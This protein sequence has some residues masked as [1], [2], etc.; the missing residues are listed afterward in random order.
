MFQQG[1]RDAALAE[2][3]QLT[4]KYPDDRAARTRLVAAYGAMNRLADAERELDTALKRNP[5]DQDALWQRGQLDLATG[6]IHQ[7]ENDL[8]KLVGFRSDSADV[9]F[10]MATVHRLKREPQLE[11]QELTEA[12]RL[13]SSF[14]AA[15]LTLARSF[16]A[17]GQ[18]E[19]ALHVLDEAPKPQKDLVSLLLERNWALLLSG[20]V[21]GAQRMVEAILKAKRL[22]DAVLQD[23]VIKMVNRN[24]AGAAQQAEEVLHAS[25]SDV[26]A[27]YLLTDA[28]LAEKQLP[29]AVERVRQLVAQNPNSTPLQM[30]L[31]QLLASSND[32]LQAR[33]AFEGAKKAGSQSSEPDVA[34][35]RLDVRE[36][37]VPEA[38]RRLQ[39]VVSRDGTNVPAL[40]GL[41]ELT[42]P[43]NPQGAI[44]LYRSVVALDSSNFVALNDLAYW[45]AKSNPDQAL[46]FAQKAVELAADNPDVQDTL[47]WIYYRKR[48][49]QT[50]LPYL[51]EA[52]KHSPTAEREFH[53]ALTYLKTGNTAA[54]QPLLASALSKD[55]E[56]FKKESDWQDP[57][58]PGRGSQRGD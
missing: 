49:Y 6:K 51:K 1:K 10:A 9:H 33:A 4:R 46:P 37:R 40:M 31:G 22:P 19:S 27:A 15:R 47:G 58:L 24:F 43:S 16:L 34:L 45:L 38:L 25:P 32:L 21:S 57:V 7:A 56:L 29:R 55:P 14:L 44:E 30:L 54:G 39:A 52:A 26:K 53:L 17:A 41:A 3:Q 20:D 8:G 48:L 12:L 5:S 2:L 36:K 50:A 35:A 13:N 11:Q 18:G 28:Y 23:A 42:G